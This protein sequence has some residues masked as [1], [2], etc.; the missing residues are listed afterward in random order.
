MTRKCNFCSENL[1]LRISRRKEIRKEF[2]KRKFCNRSCA[3][4]YQN[5]LSGKIIWDRDIINRK[6]NEIKSL[7][8][9]T[10]TWLKNNHDGLAQAIR[11]YYGRNGWRKF[12]ISI[13]KQIELKKDYT[14]S[15]LRQRAKFFIKYFKEEVGERIFSFSYSNSIPYEVFDNCDTRGYFK[16]IKY[17][18]KIK[19]IKVYRQW[20]SKGRSSE[21]T[22]YLLLKTR[23]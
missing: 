19:A 10:Y 9:Y 3:A 15:K 4:K 12:L 21:A 14:N 2:L 18:K 16:V 1:I 8:K 7:N 11:R 22:Q 20:I 17:L 5:Y 23:I 13:D 6:F